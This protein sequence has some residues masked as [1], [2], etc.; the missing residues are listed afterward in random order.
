MPKQVKVDCKFR[1]LGGHGAML[2]IH[3]HIP[4]FGNM[5]CDLRYTNLESQAMVDIV[6]RNG[7]EVQQTLDAME[8]DPTDEASLAEYQMAMGAGLMKLM[9]DVRQKLTD[10]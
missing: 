4:G 2:D 1:E 9:S 6:T 8:I 3:L 5:K 10:E 7:R